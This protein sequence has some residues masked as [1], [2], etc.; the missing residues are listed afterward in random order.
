[1][2]LPDSGREPRTVLFVVNDPRFFITHRMGL[3][4]GVRASGYD[5]HVAIPDRRNDVA[6]IEAAGFPV[7]RVPIDSQGLNPLA[8][9][10]TVFE[11]WRLYRRLRPSIVHHVT[12]KPVLYGS[13]AARLANVPSVVN[14]I[15]GLGLMFAAGTRFASLRAAMVCVAYRLFLSHPNTRVIFQ[16][17]QDRVVFVRARIVPVEHTAL[18]V[19]S[20]VELGAFAPHAVPD[21][22]PIVVLPARF[23]RQKGIREF[24]EAAGILRAEGMAARFVLV[25]DFAG[26]RD[27]VSQS[28]L[29]RWCAAG[30]IENW[31]WTDNMPSVIARSSIVC[32]PSYYREG[33]PKALI[34]GCAG[35]RPLVTTDMPGCRDV[36]ADGLNGYLIP[37]R[38]VP[39]LVTA[40]R[41]L[42]LDP[43]ARGR[44]GK[45]ARE[46][47]E[48]RYALES[49]IDATLRCYHA[50]DAANDASRGAVVPPARNQGG[51]DTV[52]T[53]S[54]TMR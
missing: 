26:N 47:A 30:V 20:G 39:A 44:M 53:V 35:G 16:N 41:R 18:I 40:L 8:D 9:F 33:V 50:L 24:A 11:L 48:A 32:L 31:G 46:I 14:A 42:L 23:L 27:A 21:D 28:D 13:L 36:V 34:D 49:V 19:G 10:Q 12:I 4:R 17:E 25:G 43:A 38:D 22:P 1:M 37:P 5:V 54:D 51:R 3:A 7:H 15:S 29:D 6:T 52:P 45:N 2:R